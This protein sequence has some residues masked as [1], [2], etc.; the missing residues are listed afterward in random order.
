[1]NSCNFVTILVIVLLVLFVFMLFETPKKEGYNT[2]V[3]V[4]TFKDPRYSYPHT[5]KHGMAPRG[6][7]NRQHFVSP[8][9]YSGSG[10]LKEVRPSL[11]YTHTPRNTWINTGGYYDPVSNHGDII[12]NAA[13]YNYIRRYNCC[14]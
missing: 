12:H 14:S 6:T 7:Y 3:P 5:T 11:N 8:G 1:M 2:H 9:F 10:L 13:N 4:K